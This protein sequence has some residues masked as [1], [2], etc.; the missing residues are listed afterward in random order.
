MNKSAARSIP[1]GNLFEGQ[2][3]P[4]WAATWRT[5]TKN[6]RVVSFTTAEAAELA[7]WRILYSIEQRVMHRDG[8]IVF[9]AKAAAEAVFRKGREIQVERRAGA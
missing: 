1:T 4:V 8:E 3:R 5:V 7:A 6:G 2:F 9:A